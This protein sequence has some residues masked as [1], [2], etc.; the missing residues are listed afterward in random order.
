MPI[1]ELGLKVNQELTR[2]IK[3][4]RRCDTKEKSHVKAQRYETAWGI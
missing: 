4:N 2:L 3:I 1:S